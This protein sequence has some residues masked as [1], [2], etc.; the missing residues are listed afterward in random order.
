MKDVLRRGREEIDSL[1]NKIRDAGTLC[2]HLTGV[3]TVHE[4]RIADLSGN[5]KSELSSN[6][7]KEDKIKNMGTNIENIKEQTKKAVDTHK[8]I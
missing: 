7:N 2:I 5:L 8:V 6:K 3:Q 4:E 1:K